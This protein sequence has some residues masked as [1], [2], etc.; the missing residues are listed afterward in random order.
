MNTMN[1]TDAGKI[2]AA[3]ESLMRQLKETLINHLSLRLSPEDISEDTTLFGTGLGLDSVDAL[4]VAMAIEADFEITVADD[5]VA[6]F[7]SLNLIADF[8]AGKQTEADFIA[9]KQ[10]ETA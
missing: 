7:R 10:T 2:G 8:I 6:S 5:D 9:D 4:Q 1:L 3:R